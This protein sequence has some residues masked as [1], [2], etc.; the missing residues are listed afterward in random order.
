MD[1]KI[2]LDLFLRKILSAPPGKQE[3]VI[4]SALQL[5]EGKPPDRLLYNGREAARFLNL[6][7]QSIWRL[8]KNDVIKPVIIPG[9][10]APKYRRADLEKLAGGNHET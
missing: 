6:S 2:T 1:E 9:M 8:V 4:A 5:L 7:Y 3:S 10:K